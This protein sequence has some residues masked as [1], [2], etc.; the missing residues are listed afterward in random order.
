MIQDGKRIKTWR[1]PNIQNF[2]RQGELEPNMVKQIMT[3]ALRQHAP[4][5]T[6]AWT[7][8]SSLLSYETSAMTTPYQDGT[9][10]QTAAYPTYSPGAGPSQSSAP[11]SSQA[12]TSSIAAGSST[13]ATQ[14]PQSR[15]SAEEARQDKT[16]AEFL[17]ML[18]DYEP[19]VR[20][21]CKQV[22]ECT[23]ALTCC[24][25]VSHRNANFPPPQI[26]NEVTD[27]YLQ[28]V[29]FECED[30]RL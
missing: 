13:Q 29:G 27:Y 18:D 30:P 16:L 17:L 14:Q 2:I 11:D 7:F 28:R 4:S 21:Y 10:Q 20:A 6:S 9:S 3:I 25:C 8:Y 23:H 5:A 22:A 15:Q 26:P 24:L 1:V 12:S 19:L